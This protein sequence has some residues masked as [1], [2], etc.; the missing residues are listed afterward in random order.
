L[1]ASPS[2]LSSLRIPF[3]AMRLTLSLLALLLTTPAALAQWSSDPANNL[4]VADA[5]SDQ[6]IS[7]IVAT[8]DGGCYVSW[9][10]GIGTGYDVRVQR[11]DA[12]GNE[13]WAHNGVLVADRSF[14]S[15]QDY[16]L[17]LDADG[18]AVLAFRDDR[19]GGVQVT[20]SKVSP[21]GVLLWGTNGVQVTSTTDFIASPRVAVTASL[22]VVV[23]W[24]Q[25]SSGKTMR[26]TSSGANVWGGPVDMTPATGSYSPSDLQAT[27]EDVILAMVHQTGSFSSP[28]HL[29]A[30]KLDAMGN[31]LW[32]ATPVGVFNGGSL[33]FGN[34]PTFV[35]DGSGGAV[36]AW[37]GTGPLQCYAQ[38]VR[39]NGAELFPHNGA[40]V[41]TNTSNTRVSPSVAFDPDSLSTYVFWEEQNSGQTLSGLSGQRF[42]VLGNRMWGSTGQTFIGLASVEINWVRTT[43]APG[44]AYVF[45]IA[46]QSFGQSTAHGSVVD[47]NSTTVAPTVFSSTSAS[48]SRLQAVTSTGGDA[49]LVWQDDSVDSGDILGQNFGPD[50]SLGSSNPVGFAYCFGIGCPCGNDD[51]SAGCLNSSGAGAWLDV[52]GS[53]SIGADDLIFD[54]IDGTAGKPA[55]LFSGTMQQNGGAGSALGDGLLCAGGTIQRMTV[56][57]LDSSGASTWGPGL[58]A[59]WGWN[60]GDLLDF[61]VW[62]RDPVVGP[63]AG[64][65]NLSNGYEVSFLP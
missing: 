58:A 53:A 31:N 65:F 38:H 3:A 61:Q 56:H 26:L 4:S 10:D 36:F 22:D 21:A 62:F 34:Y 39:A 60:A 1:E 57:I 9:F 15:T 64:G 2:F 23:S 20:A 45:W 50:G 35:L 17:D 18:N 6:A 63:C 5:G 13:Q 14:S 51:P 48:K 41:S 32:G 49:F 27:G 55:L 59:T 8:A 19:F 54:V 43:L 12:D 11:L 28:K 37:Y 24:T 40:A 29:V 47:M 30:Q 52:S 25:N 33:Q 42:D 44:G 46:T 16:D 7:K